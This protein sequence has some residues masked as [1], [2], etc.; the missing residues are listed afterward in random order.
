[1]KP[2]GATTGP[3]GKLYISLLEGYPLPIPGGKVCISP[4]EGDAVIP[5]GKLYISPLEGNAL[6]PPI[7]GEDPVRT[8]PAGKLYISLLEGNAVIPLG[9]LTGDWTAIGGTRG[10]SRRLEL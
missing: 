10:P 9:T 4:D 2:T 7:P 8:N 3:V 1:M 5:D 6:I